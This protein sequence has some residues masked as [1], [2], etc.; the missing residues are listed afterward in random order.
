MEPGIVYV[1]T[2]YYS[3]IQIV[4]IGLGW[5]SG[6]HVSGQSVSRTLKLSGNDGNQLPTYAK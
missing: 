2:G 1:E 5:Y 6:T 4:F 3:L